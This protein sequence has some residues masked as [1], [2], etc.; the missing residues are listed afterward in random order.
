ML[1]GEMNESDS[2]FIRTPGI[3]EAMNEHFV[4]K[5]DVFKA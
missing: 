5:V 2:L 1:T 4:L 3:Y